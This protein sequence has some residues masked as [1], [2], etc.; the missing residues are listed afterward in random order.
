MRTE[1]KR[2]NGRIDRDYMFNEHFIR[3]KAKKEI[4]LDLSFLRM[5]TMAKGH[6][7]I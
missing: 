2:L 5:L 6:K 1:A 4:I 7:K 3:G